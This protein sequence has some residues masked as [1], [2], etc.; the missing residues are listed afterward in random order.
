MA[1]HG[2]WFESF[3]MR[4]RTSL[5]NTFLCVCLLIALIVCL[6]VVGLSAVRGSVMRREGLRRRPLQSCSALLFMCLD[7]GA[8]SK[9]LVPRRTWV[10]HGNKCLNDQDRH[11][12]C[13]APGV[14][15]RLEKCYQEGKYPCKRGETRH[16]GGPFTAPAGRTGHLTSKAWFQRSGEQKWRESKRK[17]S[18][19]V[20]PLSLEACKASERPGCYPEGAEQRP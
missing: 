14:L 5:L 3:R 6:L 12:W 2:A 17:H 15:C 16:L 10:Q 9:C 7:P 20:S 18:L 19:I 1:N 8:W 4:R 11:T 13:Q